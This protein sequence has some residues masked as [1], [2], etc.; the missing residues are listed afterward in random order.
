[1]PEYS[2]TADIA[3]LNFNTDFL[4]GKIKDVLD[5]VATKAADS[6][7]VHKTGDET[8][9]GSKTFTGIPY[10]Q[11]SSRFKSVGFKQT[12]T[13]DIVGSVWLD[14]G[15]W[16]KV[17]SGQI[18]F[19]VYRPKETPDGSPSAHKETFRLPEVDVDDGSA[20]RSY[21]IYTTKNPPPNTWRGYQV[22]EYSCTYSCAA[23][24][25]C[26]LTA[27]NFNVS[28]P[29]G[30]T[31]FAVVKFDTATTSVCV[32]EMDATATGSEYMMRLR[33]PTSSNITNSTATIKIAYVQ[34]N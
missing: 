4:D 30:Y 32:C 5:E 16:D 21:N 6:G 29:T 28:T 8:V 2:D 11:Y 23:N 27:S 34:T 17:Q 24:S 22:K 19:E 15:A 33:N 20:D 3:D 31:P 14:T 26:N 18:G 13:G 7:V 1:M 25:T 9:A 12:G 10:A